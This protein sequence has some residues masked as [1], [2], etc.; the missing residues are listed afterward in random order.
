MR[1]AGFE[2]RFDA[3]LNWELRIPLL[4]VMLLVVLGLVFLMRWCKPG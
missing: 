3:P 1:T 4:A 2:A